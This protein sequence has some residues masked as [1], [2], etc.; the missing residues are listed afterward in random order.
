MRVVVLLASSRSN[1]NFLKTDNL[2]GFVNSRQ[3]YRA[4]HG[5]DVL[6]S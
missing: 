3:G 1:S 2:H 6:D 5:H 4:D